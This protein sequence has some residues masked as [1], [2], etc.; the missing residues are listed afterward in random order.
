MLEIGP[1]LG[2]LTE[3]LLSRGNSVIAVER[4]PYLVDSLRAW[5]DPRL[6]IVHADFLRYDLER[7][8]ERGAS[9]VISNLPYCI[10]S[11]VLERL[12]PEK[13]IQRMVL[14]VQKEVADRLRAEPG[15]REYGAATLFAQHHTTV[16]R[17][18]TLAPSCFYP[19]PDVES[20]VVRMDRRDPG[21]TETEER[22]L[23]DLV[24]A[25]FGGRRKI[26]RNALQTLLSRERA[27]DLLAAAG[28]DPQSRAETLSLE[29]FEKLARLLA[30]TS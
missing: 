4:D 28:V 11:P 21:M 12:L 10:T 26:L 22:C 7:A 25:A 13:R 29:D 27:E 30:A 24:R 14:T 1:G 19:P 8:L 3:D 23:R 15:T 20:A 18:F 2:A 16:R 6:E 5:D 9:V 17:L